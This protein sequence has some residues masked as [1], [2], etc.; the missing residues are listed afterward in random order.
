MTNVD[1]SLDQARLVISTSTGEVEVP[2]VDQL[3]PEV[4]LAAG[5][6]VIAVIPG[7]LD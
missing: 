3:V 6:L 5:Y 7:L 2:F 1:T 4:D